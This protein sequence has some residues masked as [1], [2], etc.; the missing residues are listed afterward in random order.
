MEPPPSLPIPPKEQPDAIAAASPPLEPPLE[1]AKF[2]GLLVR[3]ERRL[4]VSYAIRNSGVLVVPT[5]MAPAARKR[6][7]RGAV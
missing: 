1:C 7:T 5:T 3:P 4:S 6:V 2:H